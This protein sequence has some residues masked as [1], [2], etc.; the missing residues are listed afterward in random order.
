MLQP[1]EPIRWEP[2]PRISWH[3]VIPLAAQF[4]LTH[5]VARVADRPDIG[6]LPFGQRIFG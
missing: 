4:F 1:A 6:L 5:S 2:K 3:A